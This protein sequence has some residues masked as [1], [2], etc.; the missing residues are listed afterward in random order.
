MP[1]IRD[2][3]FDL[4]NWIPAKTLLPLSRTLIKLSSI[5]GVSGDCGGTKKKKKKS[6][7]SNSRWMIHIDQVI[8]DD[9]DKQDSD[10]AKGQNQLSIVTY[11]SLLIF[12][13]SAA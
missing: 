5:S 3:G 9:G 6:A 10:T 7:S 13:L 4:G 1:L 2:F 8:D 11:H 12:H